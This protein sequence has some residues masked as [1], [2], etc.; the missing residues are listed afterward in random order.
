MK[1]LFLLFAVAALATAQVRTIGAG[2]SIAVRIN[3]T[4][5]ARQ[6]DGRV[7]TGVV[8]EDVTDSNGNVAIPRGSDVELIVRNVSSNEM[9]LD[10]ESVTANGQ[11]YSLAA[12]ADVSNNGRRNGLGGNARTGEYVGG[13]ALLGTIIGAIAGGGRGAAIGAGAGAA[14][15]AGTQ[16]MTRGGYVNIPA[17]SVV[18]FRLEQSLQIATS[19]YGYDR[20]GQHYHGADPNANTSYNAATFTC[21]SNNGRRVHCNIDT[22]GGVQM[23]R[24]LSGSPCREGAT[25][26]SDARG[27]WVDRGCRAEFS[28]SGNSADRYRGRSITCSSDNGQRVYCEAGS[29]GEVRLVRQI[30]GS[31]CQEGSTWGHDARGIWVDRGCRA[32]FEVR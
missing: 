8:Y 2:A 24:Q 14:A 11:R 32:E 19:H 15:G 30:S 13:G 22:R 3:Q 6:S 12:D 4:I 26:G 31:A 18:T 1:S 10:L 5:D 9:V 20:G 7:F 25:W 27:V 16:V 17:E 21:S 28:T 29:Q 23:L